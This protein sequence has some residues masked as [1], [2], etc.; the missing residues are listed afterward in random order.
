MSKQ[1][2]DRVSM[3]VTSDAWNNHVASSKVWM[4][5][6]C[7]TYFLINVAFLYSPDNYNFLLAKN[8]NK[9]L[10]WL[11]F[12]LENIIVNFC[13]NI[14]VSIVVILNHEVGLLPN[15][16]LNECATR[17]ELVLVVLHI[18]LAAGDTRESA[19]TY[20][21]S[22]KAGSVTSWP[23]FLHSSPCV[24]NYDQAISASQSGQLWYV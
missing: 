14:H 19:P 3:H 10:R 17:I 1:F 5:I 20:P 12:L 16:N 7:G 8:K 24:V 18:Y 2:P 6:L 15:R 9:T 4:L 23:F 11:L 22:M 21:N 13:L